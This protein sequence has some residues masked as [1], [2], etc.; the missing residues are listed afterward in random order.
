MCALCISVWIS[1]SIIFMFLF[2][3]WC[4][5]THCMCLCLSV[6]G[7]L[8]IRERNKHVTSS[9]LTVVRCHHVCHIV[10]GSTELQAERGQSLFPER[11]CTGGRQAAAG[12]H[13]LPQ[14]RYGSHCSQPSHLLLMVIL[15]YWPSECIHL[16][17]TASQA[18]GRGKETAFFNIHYQWH[19]ICSGLSEWV[20]E[21]GQAGRDWCLW[22]GREMIERRGGEWK[23]WR[24]REMKVSRESEVPCTV[25]EERWN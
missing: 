1:I 24:G 5:K 17:V 2:L 22:L 8:F 23:G 16:K 21:S 14:I 25:Y 12:S 20:S 15:T 7:I 9:K 13:H 19:S 11:L 4:S 6:C 10:S 3:F 18:R